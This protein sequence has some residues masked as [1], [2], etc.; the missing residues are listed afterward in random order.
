MDEK[1]FF[2]DLDELIIEAHKNQNKIKDK[3][4]EI[5]PTYKPEVKK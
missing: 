3:A 5:C 2:V 4:K 1:K